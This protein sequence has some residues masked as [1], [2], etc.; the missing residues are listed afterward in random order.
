MKTIF[1][2]ILSMILIQGISQNPRDVF[3]GRY[4]PPVSNESLKN[5]RMLSDVIP[6][7]PKHWNEIID[8]VSVKILAVCEGEARLAESKTEKITRDQYDVLNLADVGTDISIQIEFKWKDANSARADNGSVIKM[9]EFKLAVVPVTEAQY[10]GG[11]RELKEYLENNIASKLPKATKERPVIPGAT[12]VFT[13]DENGEV[14]GVKILN[15]FPAD[16]EVDKLLLEG[17]S[18]MPKWKPALN[19]KGEKVKQ[20]FKYG[21]RGGAY[22]K[23]GC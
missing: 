22:S 1:T 16:P 19:S 17:L 18:K 14:S 21:I 4:I 5:A 23:G 3:A 20:E 2:L 8:I 15:K 9:N 13:I 12:A 7:C 6:D 10:P 11:A